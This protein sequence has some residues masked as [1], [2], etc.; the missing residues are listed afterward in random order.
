MKNPRELADKTRYCHFHRQNRHDTEECR[1]L[2]RQIEELIRRGHLSHYLWQNKELSLRPE[3]PVERQ[4]D[5]ITG[6]PAYGGKI[7]TGQKAYTHT[8]TAEDPGHGPAPEVTFP[9]ER[10]EPPKHDD[11]LVVAAI[12]AN[13][14]VKRV[15][16]DTGSSADILYLDAFQKLGLSHDALVTMS[17]ALT[18]FTYKSILPLG[19]TVLPLTL[20][21]APRTKTVM[22][23]FLVVDLP[24]AYNAILGRPTLNKLRAVIST[25]HRTV[26]FPTRAGVGEAKG[27]PRESRRCY[28][29]TI[30]LHK[31]RRAELPLKDPREIKRSSRH[32]EPTGP[33]VDVPLQD[34]RP[35][36]TVKVGSELLEHE[37]AR[38]I[39]LLQENVDVFAWSPTDMAGVD[40]EVSQH[41]LCISPDARP[42][43]QRPRRLAP[44]RQQ[45]VRGEVER[46]LA[47]GFIEEAKYP[48]WLSNV[49]LVK[50]PNGSWRICVDYT[51]LNRACPKDCYPLPRIDQLV[52][53]MAGHARLSFMDAFSGY[54][55]IRMALE[56]QQHTAFLTDQGVYFYK[57]M[58]F[59]LKNAGATYQRTVNKMFAHQI[60]RNM[61]VY[62]DDMIV[63]SRTTATHLPDL[64][65]TFDTLRRYNIRLNPAKCAFGINSGKFLGFII[66]ERGINVNP[67]KVWAIIDMQA[68][69]AIKELQRLNGRLAALSRFLS[70]SGDR[71]LP[72]FRALKNPQEFAWTAECG[73][74][75]AHIKE[76]LASLPRLASVSPQEKLGIYLAASQNAVSSVLIKEAPGGQ[77]PVYYTS[78]VLNGPE[79][80]YPPIEKLALALVL[81]ARK[82]RPYFQAHPI[83]YVPRTAIKA[84]AVADFISEL[85][86][87]KG[88][89]LERV[90]REWLLRVDGSSGR[91]GAGVGLV[92]EVPDGRSFERSLRYGFKATNNEAEYEAL[93]AGLRLVVEMQ[94]DDKHILTDS[95]L[96]A[97][98]LDGRYEARDPTMSKYLVEVRALAAH[99]SRFVLSRVPKR[100]NE[101]ADTLAKLASRLN[102]LG[103]PDVEELP[104]RA[105]TVATV[106]TADP[107]TT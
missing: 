98:Q 60:G 2:K 69:R 96:V 64:A 9:A 14:Q 89:E 73:E 87:P 70:R 62:I 93:L 77:Q 38:L 51:D 80:R 76:H 8:P 99:F 55:Q 20:G 106:T 86:R 24:T 71:C 78:H 58:P 17:S 33:T 103:K 104:T 13:A 48:H 61:E 74:A 88:E 23:T 107:P 15:M 28:L 32:P 37:R 34:G 53:A 52:D 56:D 85:T 4:I 94:V 1:E 91:K 47:V 79:E 3:G 39:N 35:D 10:A 19:T 90:K 12:I 82:L 92:L 41:H 31:R 65:E 68:P 29:T 75:F 42:V 100:Q 84:H 66:H 102:P 27:N 16:V 50:K 63:K 43:K 46:L 57:V 95:Q 101:R 97:E 5:V 59:G 21:E 36:Q 67:D 7:M 18:G 81:T 30:S 105:I 11:A 22:I 72:F 26:K 44:E 49:V 54:N 6:G 40:L 83:E 45:V 25:Y